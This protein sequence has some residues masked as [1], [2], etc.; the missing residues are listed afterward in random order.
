LLYK[1]IMGLDIG[2]KR[3]GISLSDPLRITA[4]GL[5]TYTRKDDESDVKYLAHV[6]NDNKCEF[7]VSGLPKNMNGT[8]GPQAEKVI[9]LCEMLKEEIGCSIEYSDE[10]LTT[11]LVERTLIEADMSRQKRRKVVDKLAAVNILQG[12]LDSH[13]F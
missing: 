1:K 5:E 9:A 6:F 8:L 12:Y 7:I 4:Q 10:R 11:M 2:D 13:H 3:I